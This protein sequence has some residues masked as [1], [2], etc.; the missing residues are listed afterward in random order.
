L[1]TARVAAFGERAGLVCLTRGPDRRIWSRGEGAGLMTDEQIDGE[2]ISPIYVPFSVNS[3]K[4]PIREQWRPGVH[5]D[6]GLSSL[7]RQVLDVDH[8][9]QVRIGGTTKFDDLAGAYFVGQP[10]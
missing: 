6:T 1:H 10:A 8:L 4:L 3:S 7:V 5:V 2:T 9:G